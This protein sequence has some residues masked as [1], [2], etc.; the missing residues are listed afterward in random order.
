[1]FIRA[2]LV[3]SFR[4]AQP[5]LGR[6]VCVA[7]CLTTSL[8]SVPPSALAGVDAG[9]VGDG[10]PA[11]CTETALVTAL[12][13]GG[14]VTFNCGGP[15]TITLTAAQTIAQPTNI[16]GGS[17]ITLTSNFASKLFIVNVG[18][19]LMLRNIT[20]Y[21]AYGGATDGGAIVNHG[22]LHLDHSRIDSGLTDV[23][24]S[25]GAIF[26]DGPAYITDSVFINNSGGS[27]GAIFANFGN[28][29]VSIVRGEFSN[30]TA[31]NTTTGYGG[32]IWV[33]TQAT[34]DV[35]DS[36]F[37]SNIGIYGGALYTTEGSTVTVRTQNTPD[38]TTFSQNRA[39]EDGGAIVNNATLWISNVNFLG[40]TIPISAP[41][42]YGGAIS[43]LGAMTLTSGYMALNEG[44]FG[45]AIF[46]G[47][48]SDASAVVDKTIFNKNKAGQFG[49]G[50][51]TNVETTTLTV[52]N[53]IF[54]QNTAVVGGGIARVNAR[55]T[56]SRTSFVENEATTGGGVY[57]TYLPNNVPSGPYTRIEN[58]TFSGNKATSNQ[59]GGV[60]NEGVGLELYYA[61]LKDNT[62]GVFSAGNSNTRLRNAVLDN[63][64]TLNCD[65][66]TPTPPSD[67]AGNFATDTSC[68]LQ[69]THVVTD[70][71]L[72]PL[73]SDGF[74][75]TSYHMPIT[76]SVVINAGHTPCPTLDQRGAQRPDACDSGAVEYGGLLPQSLLP[77]LQK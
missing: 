64:G 43:N 49:G 29:Q 3:R 14:A 47:G 75:T 73:T 7:A 58:V 44:R 67:D 62:N 45:G 40:N 2:R 24:H 52:K 53:S 27:A 42:H 19:P 46:N 10:T 74:G 38:T 50:I 18:T 57:L 59:G 32:A 16:D 34:L 51:Y 77:F 28:A 76:G 5:L 22:T 26:T 37:S 39:I 70:V 13:N 12:T 15:A 1:M 65:G 36:R 23:N 69:P 25:G 55:F 63:P 20:L 33:G 72:G 21:K 71:K 54:Y 11:S 41:F 56:I 66:T 35:V 31:Q 68:G 17:Q 30:N 60:Y 8:A 9:V 61:T 4:L 6:V 48:T